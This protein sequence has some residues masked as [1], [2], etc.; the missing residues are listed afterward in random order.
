MVVEL[1]NRMPKGRSQQRF[2]GK[3]RW[4]ILAIVK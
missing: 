1:V 2:A 3:F 4:A